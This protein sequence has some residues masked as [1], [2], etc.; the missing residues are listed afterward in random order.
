MGLIFGGE[1]S[2]FV[3]P[4]VTWNEATKQHDIAYTGRCVGIIVEIRESE[5]YGMIFD[6][7]TTL[8]VDELPN[9]AAVAAFKAMCTSNN[10]SVR[11]CADGG[12]SCPPPPARLLGENGRLCPPPLNQLRLEEWRKGLF[13]TYRPKMG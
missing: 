4:D 11:G 3:T 7:V 8:Y 9:E 2:C 12:T 13:D 10:L 1:P 5:Q 6:S